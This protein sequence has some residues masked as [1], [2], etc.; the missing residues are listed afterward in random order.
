MA[1]TSAVII[2]ATYAGPV[3]A[4]AFLG[5]VPIVL[6]ISGN[7]HGGISWRSLQVPFALAVLGLLLVNGQSIAQFEGQS[8]TT[9][10][11]GIGAS[12]ASVALWG[13]FGLANQILVNV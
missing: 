7:F 4:P 3:V 6:A 5:L 8:H 2:A 11:L 13:W 1:L 12:L 9:L 10:A